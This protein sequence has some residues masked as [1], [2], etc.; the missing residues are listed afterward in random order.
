VHGDGGRVGTTRGCQ[1]APTE[2]AT[3]IT[4]KGN[5]AV[6]HRTLPKCPAPTRRYRPRLAAGTESRRPAERDTGTKSATRSSGAGFAAR[7]PSRCPRA[8]ASVPYRAQGPQAAL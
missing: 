5:V 6:A 8:T 2:I 3:E 1:P 4:A 7:K